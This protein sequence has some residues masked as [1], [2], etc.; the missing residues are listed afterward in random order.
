MNETTKNIVVISSLAALT[1]LLRENEEEV[2]IIIPI[3]AKKEEES[4]IDPKYFAGGVG[5]GAVIVASITALAYAINKKLTEMREN[6][7]YSI[8]R[9]L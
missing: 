8:M 1:Y 3:E 5:I 2:E 9:K 6:I 4:I 7:H